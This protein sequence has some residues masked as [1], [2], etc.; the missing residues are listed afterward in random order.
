MH[1]KERK[2]LLDVIRYFQY[3]ARQEI[4]LQGN[5]NNDNFTQLL[6]LL[7]MKGENII[8]H[9]DGTIGNKFT[10]HDIHNE[11]LNIMSR[12]VL[13]SQLETICKKF[14]FSIMADE[15]TYITNKKQFSICIHIVDGALEVKEDF[16]GFYEL[17]NKKSLAVV[18]AVKDNLLRYN[19]NL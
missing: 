14:H 17:E 4:A 1:E 10:H 5:E 19:L 12:H 7:E 6:M 3:P 9:L 2:Y 16:R 11:S 15:Y 8:A 13:L 18:N